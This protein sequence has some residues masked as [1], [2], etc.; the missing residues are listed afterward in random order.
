MVDLKAGR[1]LTER[2]Q[3]L[4]DWSSPTIQYHFNSEGFPQSSVDLLGFFE[5]SIWI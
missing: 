2:F 3:R 4:K 5:D 1:L